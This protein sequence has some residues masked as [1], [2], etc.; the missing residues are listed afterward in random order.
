MTRAV[1]LSAVRTPIGD[2]PCFDDLDLDGLDSAAYDDTTILAALK[3]D[4]SEWARE[5][6]S[7]DTWYATIGG[8]K[9]PD[10]LRQQ[11][12]NLKQRLAAARRNAHTH[13]RK[14]D[15]P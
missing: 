10:A 1:I 7:I 12:G 13:P 14:G 3:V 5:I 8:N 11:L 9:L 6:E 2:V 15:T 4:P